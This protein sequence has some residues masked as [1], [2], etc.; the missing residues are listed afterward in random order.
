[1]RVKLCRSCGDADF[2]ASYRNAFFTILCAACHEDA[3]R[4]AEARERDEQDH[5]ETRVWFA[6]R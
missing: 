4:E 1:M 5:P 3:K 6:G 2:T